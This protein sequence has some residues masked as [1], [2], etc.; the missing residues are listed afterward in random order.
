MSRRAVDLV[1]VGTFVSLFAVTIRGVWTAIS[2]GDPYILGDWQINYVG[3]FV[4]RGLLGE[5]PRYGLEWF[6]VDTRT[7]V[8]AVQFLV[9]GAF[10]GF[11]LPLV[12]AAI[13]R[14]PVFAF[15]AASPL[16]FSF[17]AASPSAAGRKEIVFLATLSA[18][19]WRLN[20][21]SKETRATL[22]GLSLV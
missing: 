16:A 2:M 17:G 4:R 1:L 19:A 3:G 13:A 10:F 7:T 8:F 5:L 15:A 9:Y 12:A 6:G 21:R 22:C 11:S 14:Y 18:L 20:R